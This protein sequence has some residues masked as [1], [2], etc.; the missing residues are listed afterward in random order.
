MK[1]PG[2]NTAEREEL[3]KVLKKINKLDEVS[4][5]DIYA[6]AKIVKN[7]EWNEKELEK[8]K[9]F[10]EKDTSYRLNVSKKWK[11]GY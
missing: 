7:E 8:L 3:L 11:R 1:F 10:E 6:L 9:K 4:D 5:L 2:K